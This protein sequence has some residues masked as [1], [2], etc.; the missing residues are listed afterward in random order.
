[1][2]T[3]LLSEDA[4]IALSDVELVRVTYECI[5]TVEDDVVCD[6]LFW[7]VGEAFERFA[8]EVDEAETERYL[9]EDYDNPDIVDRERADGL[10]ARRR[11][12]GA[13]MLKRALDDE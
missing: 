6:S 10:R 7:L 8:P 3:Y 13:R 1:M 2:S 4:A 11:R 12:A 5:A 9:R